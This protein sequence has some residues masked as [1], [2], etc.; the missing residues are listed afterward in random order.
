MGK[1]TFIGAGP[2]DAGLITVKGLECLKAADVI[3]YDRLTSGK[4]LE[5]AKAGAELIYVGKKPGAHS[6]KQ[7]EINRILVEQARKHSHV[8]RLK[9]GDSFVFGRGGEEIEALMQENLSY[10]LVPGITSAVAV[11]ESA[12]I[13][14]THRGIS[15]S[16]H[17]ITGHTKDGKEGLLAD[18]KTLAK[19]EGTLI[20]LMGLSNLEQ[21]TAN[22]I[23]CGKPKET[24]AAVIADGT[25]PTEHCVRGTLDDISEKV[26]LAHMKSPVIIVIGENA[27][28]HFKDTRKKRIFGLIG[29]PETSRKF[30]AGLAQRAEESAGMVEL[31]RMEKVPLPETEELANIQKNI[32]QYDWIFFTSKQAV[33]QFFQTAKEIRLDNRKL[34]ACRFAAL[35]EG[36]GDALEEYGIYADFMPKQADGVSLAAEFAAAYQKAAEA[37]RQTIK[38]LLPRAK[39]GS[40]EMVQILRQ[41]G[42]FVKDLSI[43][44]VQGKVTEQWEQAGN[45]RDFVFF[46]AS[47]AEVFFAELTRTGRQLPAESRCFCIG[48][49]TEKA[50]QA[51]LQKEA[52]NS[53]GCMIYKA[54]R[55]TVDGLLD[56]IFACK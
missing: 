35:G 54:E 2:G 29:T 51:V 9:G 14:V 21:I 48:H 16:F 5:Y 45:I 55:H 37:E 53:G 41:A 27:A 15:R 11:P 6:M 44:D 46:S 47:G 38:I 25:L 24:P 34:A 19:L 30:A 31:I 26:R 49:L 43:Y 33:K 28:F 8:V 56:I 50:L 23:K 18:F 20:F 12:G 10:E 40:Q 52:G 42:F 22:L 13:P 17:V 39:K 4:L 32:G 1:V 3:I 7:E 36:T